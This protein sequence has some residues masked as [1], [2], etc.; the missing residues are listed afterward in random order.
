MGKS[1][2]SALPCL[3]LAAILFCS[4]AATSA[5]QEDSGEAAPD[6]VALFQQAQDRHEKG[7]FAAAIELYDKA[8]AAAPEFPEALY[9]RGNALQSLGRIDEAEKSFRKAVETRPDWTLALANLGSLLVGKGVY[10]E[11]EKLLLKAISLDDQN[12]L[13]YSALTELRLKSKAGTEQLKDL[14]IRLTALTDRARP[15][16][17]AWAARGA[18]ETAL[19]EK[20]A[21]RASFNRALQLEPKN[22]FAL[23]AKA[24]TAIDEGDLVGAETAVR[25]LE[26]LAAA[27]P[28]VK[29]LRARLLFAS[30]KTDEAVAK[31]DSIENPPPDVVE[32]RDRMLL[33]KS[34]SG[35]ELE[36][37]LERRPDDPFVLG[38]LCA[39]FRTSDPAKALTYCRKASEA[40]PS[41]INHAIGFGAALVQAKMFVEA[42]DLFR[43][44]V[45][46]SPENVTVRANLATALF[47]LKR[48]PEARTEYRWITEKQPTSAIAYYFL[49]ITHDQLMEY[50]DAMANYQ[51]FLKNADAE[52]NKLEIEKVNLRLPVLQKQIKEKKGKSK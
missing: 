46:I 23:A 4:F 41:N 25:N 19:G 30:G 6:P 26:T 42:V 1:A 40:E 10:P 49:G 7:E 38:R 52:K 22:Q 20:A 32:L 37:R 14:L 39:A 47:Q 33:S 36:R 2:A 31:L 16:A 9:Q 44:L 34:E 18:L 43:G 17:G 21:A 51:L 48:Y 27:A 11:A 45:R 13:A 15:T 5:A 50:P 28:S 12:A 8:L 29:S 35:P 3:I 24:G